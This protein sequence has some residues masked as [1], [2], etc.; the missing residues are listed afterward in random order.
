MVELYGSDS[1]VLQFK[2]Y[3]TSPRC[4]DINFPNR[5]SISLINTEEIK[6]LSSVKLKKL[7]LRFFNDCYL[8]DQDVLHLKQLYGLKIAKKLKRNLNTLHNI[9]ISKYNY[10]ISIANKKIASISETAVLTNT[11]LKLILINSK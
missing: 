6:K 11:N 4:V 2:K 10:D 8:M 5:Y 9:V 3:E 1:T 7:C